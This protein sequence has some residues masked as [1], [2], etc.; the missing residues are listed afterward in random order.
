[1]GSWRSGG[2]HHMKIFKFH[3]NIDT[4]VFAPAWKTINSNNFTHSAVVAIRRE[5]DM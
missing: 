4:G 1:M 5:I 3:Q 2:L